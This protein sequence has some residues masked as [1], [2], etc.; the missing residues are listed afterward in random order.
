MSRISL[1]YPDHITFL[2]SCSFYENCRTTIGFMD[3]QTYSNTN[4]IRQ[5]SLMSTV[6][7]AI[8]ARAVK[9]EKY[10]TYIHDADEQIKQSFAGPTPDLLAVQA[11]MLLTAWTGRGRIWG[12][13]GSVAIELGLNTAALQLGDDEIEH[14]HEIVERARTWFSICCFDLVQVETF[15]MAKLDYMLT[16]L[17]FTSQSTVCG[18]SD[19]EVPSIC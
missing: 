4:D 1:L 16:L 10:Q 9:P 14:T 18:E 3:D 17:K 19:E 6:I 11:M 2:T 15:Q 5:H 13:I 7:C 12:Y 8:A